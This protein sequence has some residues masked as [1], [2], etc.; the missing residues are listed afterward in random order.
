MN[1][2]AQTVEHMAGSCRRCIQE[3]IRFGLDFIL[4]HLIA[5]PLLQLTVK[6]PS[7]SLSTNMQGKLP[8]HHSQQY[9]HHSV[10]GE[11]SQTSYSKTTS[12]LHS[13]S[14][15]ALYQENLLLL[16][17]SFNRVNFLHRLPLGQFLV[18]PVSPSVPIHLYCTRNKS[19][20]LQEQDSSSRCQCPE[21]TKS[22]PPRSTG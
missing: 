6:A 15:R 12:I 8:I 14:H 13:H 4:C 22:Q 19:L 10:L 9:A 1:H 3:V 7:S 11:S 21:S 20:T 5:T 2:S 18:P 17:A 16:Q